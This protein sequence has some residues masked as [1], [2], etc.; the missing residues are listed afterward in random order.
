MKIITDM[1]FPMRYFQLSV[2]IRSLMEKKRVFA[3][4]RKLTKGWTRMRSK[5]ALAPVS[6]G[7]TYH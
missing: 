6:Q 7:V 1:I 5:I 4:I 2:V 3:G